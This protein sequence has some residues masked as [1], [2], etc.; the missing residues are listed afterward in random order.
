MQLPR[1]CAP[2]HADGI[3]GRIDA[4][5]AQNPHDLPEP[6]AAA[7]FEIRF[8]VQVARGRQGGL[9]AEIRQYR[10]GMRVAVQLTIFTAF[11]VIDHDGD[12]DTGRLRPANLR[13]H[14]RRIRSDRVDRGRKAS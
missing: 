3:N 9:G 11:L 5:F 4:P 10:L 14:A 8:D 13:R 12:G 7:V 6:D 2:G 1:D